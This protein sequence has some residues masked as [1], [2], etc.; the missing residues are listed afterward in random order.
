LIVTVKH[1]TIED[2]SARLQVPVPTL[3]RW[4]SRG[5]GPQYIHVGRHVRYRV[6]D[7][8]TWERAHESENHPRIA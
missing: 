3:Y 2:L 1:L 4:N 6:T 8:E 7:V 5:T